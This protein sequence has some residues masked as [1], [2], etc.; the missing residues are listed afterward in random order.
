MLE[1][2]EGSFD[3]TSTARVFRP[4]FDPFEAVRYLDVNAL[5]RAAHAEIE[6]GRLAGVPCCG[7]LAARLL[8][9]S[10]V[11]VEPR[12]APGATAVTRGAEP[13]LD[14]L[15]ERGQ[16]AVHAE[17]RPLPLP[18]AARDFFPRIADIEIED[19]CIM[20]C[21]LGIC[22]Y[23]CLSGRYTICTGPSRPGLL[24]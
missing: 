4:R 2:C 21:I 18:M 19:D 13:A 20:I 3:H 10:V 6:I 14:A 22:C 24:A 16:Q 12:P 11:G 7:L 1:I 9:G 5:G 15:I 23:S 17:R 8:D